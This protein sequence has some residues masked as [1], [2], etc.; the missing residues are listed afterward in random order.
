MEMW[1]DGSHDWSVAKERYGLF[2]KDR[3]RR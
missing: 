2:R 3:K 1:W